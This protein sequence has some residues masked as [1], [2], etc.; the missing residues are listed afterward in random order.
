M[1]TT[2]I[3][4]AADKIKNVHRDMVLWENNLEGLKT[5]VQ[6]LA[7]QKDMIQKQIDEKIANANIAMSEQRGKLDAERAFVQGEREKLAAGKVE[8]AE[9]I[10]TLRVAKAAFEKERETVQRTLNAAKQARVNADQFI[11]AV[12]RA[13]GVL[14]G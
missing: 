3:K 4:E 11:I 10:E 9:Q 8:M 5:K 1:S 14:G 13:Y 2:D 12:N 7:R 6:D